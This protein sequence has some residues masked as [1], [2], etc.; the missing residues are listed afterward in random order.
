VL[1]IT[2]LRDSDLDARVSLLQTS[3]ARILVRAVRAGAWDHT[4]DY[5]PFGMSGILIW[6][7]MVLQAEIFANKIYIESLDILLGDYQ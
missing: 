6:H 7:G 5:D 1:K 3:V 4:V 2:N